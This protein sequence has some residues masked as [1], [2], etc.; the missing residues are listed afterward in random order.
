MA[1]SASNTD[2]MPSTGYTSTKKLQTALHKAQSDF[3]SDV[4]T[5]P[6]ESMIQVSSFIE[7][8]SE[9]T[10]KSWSQ[11]ILD[12]SFG[13]DIYDTEGDVSVNALQDKL[14][15]WTGMEAGL[16]TMSGTMGN[17]ICLRTHLHQPPHTVLLDHRAHVQCWESEALPV[18]SQASVT[19][20]HPENGVHLTL[21]DVKKNIIADG[22]S[23]LKRVIGLTIY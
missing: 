21:A 18:F 14:V 12:A 2:I 6:T 4:V 15:E 22:N 3:R 10:D 7:R 13:D 19:A 16:W 8:C 20:V 1:P 17:Q 11:A 9:V 23:E 5:V